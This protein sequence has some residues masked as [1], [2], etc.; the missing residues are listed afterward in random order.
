MF[1]NQHAPILSRVTLNGIVHLDQMYEEKD[2]EKS[3][4]V[5]GG[6][7]GEVFSMGNQN[8]LKVVPF[9]GIG[10]T[11]QNDICSE[12]RISS[13]LSGCPGFVKLEKSFV[14]L[15]DHHRLQNNF[16]V[17]FNPSQLFVGLEYENCGTD[18]EK[19]FVKN[20]HQAL[21]VFNQVAHTLAVAEEAWNFEHR[22]LSLS[23][24]LI[25][26]TKEEIISFIIDGQ[27]VPVKTGGVKTSIS[28]FSLSRLQDKEGIVFRDL[29]DVDK[30]FLGLDE[31]TIDGDYQYDVYRMMDYNNVKENEGDWKKYDPVTNIYWLYYLIRKMTEKFVEYSKDN[32]L[33]KLMEIKKVLLGFKSASEYVKNG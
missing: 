12:V 27:T 29:D 5:G 8:F 28:D 18:L 19:E 25:K 21:C 1:E 31:D 30:L 33:K 15:E 6:V 2:L 20:P 32:D 17:M 3:S 24:I 13:I 26:E 14:F 7:F 9:G 10:Q 22:D 11:T 16:D 4:K 23:N